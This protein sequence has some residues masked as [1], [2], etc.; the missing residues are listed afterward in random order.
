MSFKWK[1]GRQNSGYEKLTLCRF[2]F[3]DLYLLRYK[4]GAYIKK[5]VDAVSNR[6]H[7]RLNVVLKKVEGGEFICPDA[8]INTSRIK[9]FRPDIH[10]HS[11]SEVLS[12]T[13]YV[14]S[15]GWALK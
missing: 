14:L 7:F 15:L 9:F 4:Q 11:V 13:R 10:E 8:F 1:L 5:H 3:F 6:K 2:I 12:G